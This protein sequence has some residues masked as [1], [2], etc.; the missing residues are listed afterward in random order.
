MPN[1]CLKQSK[2]KQ[3]LMSVYYFFLRF[4]F[5]F[6]EKLIYSNNKQNK[7][8][9]SETTG[10]KKK[11]SNFYNKIVYLKQIVLKFDFFSKNVLSYPNIFIFQLMSFTIT[12]ART[13]A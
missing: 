1:K 10:T 6:W 4:K 9:K 13:F 2:G 12:I 3:N 7:K 5:I 11:K 8:S